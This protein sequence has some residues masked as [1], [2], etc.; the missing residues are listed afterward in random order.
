M[1]THIENWKAQTPYAVEF[2]HN[3]ARWALTIHAV[4]DADAEAKV[5]SLRESAVLLGG[6]VEEVSIHNDGR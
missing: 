4:D 1:K 5:R 2:H 3:G 6:P